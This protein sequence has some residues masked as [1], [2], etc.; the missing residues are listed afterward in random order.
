MGL[1]DSHVQINEIYAFLAPVNHLR[2]LFPTSSLT[3]LKHVAKKGA[4]NKAIR[5][6]C[7]THE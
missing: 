5:R 4:G 7:K 6:F 1:I 3:T 2:G